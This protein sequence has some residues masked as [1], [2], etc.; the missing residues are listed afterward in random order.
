M[1]FY[2]PPPWHNRFT[3]PPQPRTH[4]RSAEL[5]LPP[6]GRAG[7]TRPQSPKKTPSIFSAVM[8]A[9]SPAA[10]EAAR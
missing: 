2:R 4:A 1:D 8:M 10:L 3:A 9:T 7:V 5:L 6:P